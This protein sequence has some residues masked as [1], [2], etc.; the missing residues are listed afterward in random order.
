MPAM[1]FSLSSPSSPIL[2][3]VPQLTTM[4]PYII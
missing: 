4:P 3:L 1:F 2:A